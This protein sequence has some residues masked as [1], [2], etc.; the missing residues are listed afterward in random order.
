[1]PTPFRYASQVVSTKKVISI[2]FSVQVMSVTFLVLVMSIT[3]LVDAHPLQLRLQ[4]KIMAV[5]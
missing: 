5:Q 1:M 2:T 4:G 3:F